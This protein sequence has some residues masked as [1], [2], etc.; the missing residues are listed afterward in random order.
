MFALFVDRYRASDVGP[1]QERLADALTV[2]IE[3][4]EEMRIEAGVGEPSRLNL[5][6]SDG[7][8]A[9]V[10]R[11]QSHD[12]DLSHSL[13][14]AKGGRYLCD[15]EHCRMEPAWGDESAVIVA[16]EPLNDGPSWYTVPGNHLVLVD[17]DL[18]VELRPIA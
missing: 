16:S 18:E 10:S 12:P 4:V 3:Q 15:G 8:C 14:F 9:V 2:T 5:A 17:A 6:V 13:C 11:Y 7:S 1:P